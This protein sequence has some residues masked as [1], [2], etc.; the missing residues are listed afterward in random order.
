MA[1]PALWAAARYEI[2]IIIVVFNNLCYDNE[3]NRLQDR[4]PLYTNKNTRDQWKDITGYLGDPDVDFTG[5]AKSFAIEGERA[6][7]PADFRKALKRARSVTREGRPYLIDAMVMQ[8]EPVRS[9]PKRG[10]YVKTEQVWY[11]DVSI[12]RG[13]SRK[14]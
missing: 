2:P 9:G 6:A 13:R 1:M 8:V 3:R 10:S 14:V 7:T 12:A 4:S 5:L 11:P